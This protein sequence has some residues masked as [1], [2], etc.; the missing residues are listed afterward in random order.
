[1]PTDQPQI[2]P[3]SSTAGF[4]Q[5]LPVLPPRYTVPTNSSSALTRQDTAD[6][7]VFARI[8]SLYLP[9]NPPDHLLRS[10]HDF[11]RK[12][13][14]PPILAHSVD[15]EVNQPVLRP[16]TTFGE[17]NRIDPLWTTGGWKGLRKVAVEGGVAASGH[18]PTQAPWNRRI[19]QFGKIHVWATT[20]AVHMCPMSMTD[21]AATCLARHLS[22]EDGDQPGRGKA[23]N[24]AYSRLISTDND[25]SWTSGQWMTERSGGSDVSGTETLATRLSS[26]EI[27]AD[28]KANG[29][30]DAI[31]MPLGPWRID[32]FKWFSSATDSDMA[33]LLARTEKGISMFYAPTRRSTP[34]TAPDGTQLVLPELNGIRIQRLK[35]KVGTKALP[36]AELELKGMR[37]YLIG[38]EGKGVKEITALINVTRLHNAVRNASYWSHGLAVA[39][40]YSKIRQIRGGLLKD[41]AQHL[42][43]MADETVKYRGA[44]HLAYFA[45]SLVGVEQQGWDSAAKGTRA[46]RLIPR[47]A[48]T[49]T[50]L[51]RLITPVA[52]AQVT[53]K[54]TAGV[55]SCMESLGGVGYC[56]N[57]EHGGILNLARI[58][59]DSAVG[60]IWEGTTS[61]MAEDVV[62]V[63]TDVRLGDGDVLQNALC[64]WVD[65]VLRH[66]QGHFRDQC[67]VVRQRLDCLVSSLQGIDRDVMHWKGREIL[68]GIEVVV[69][70]CLLMYDACIDLDH[71]AVA[72]ANRW[73]RSEV[74][75]SR[76]H[77]GK[78]VELLQEQRLDKEIF[79]G[80]H[81][82]ARERPRL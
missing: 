46:E 65:S 51:M 27:A 8:L 12:A 19:H 23:L 54:G 38:E 26:Q 7:V 50:A 14:S 72:V 71:V 56:E 4:F 31:G 62:R 67:A 32:G 22:D 39:R 20:A 45:V 44:M 36:T 1:M 78:D 11:S 63:L 70:A 41:N 77:A 6:D 28:N 75:G 69:V 2:Q 52:K 3:S 33:M 16:L 29:D 15:A 13:I 81:G 80:G 47:D 34:R 73:V 82:I 48:A 37:A 68:E 49:I 35:N 18:V 60:S 57:N 40:A 30:I 66:C 53:L 10:I 9:R 55:R 61:V 74:A 42:R 64:R 76:Y 5:A 59:R 25:Y 43:W 21:G 24:E 17:E 79:L 58:W